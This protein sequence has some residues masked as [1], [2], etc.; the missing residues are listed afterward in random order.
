MTLI[1]R[2]TEPFY[3]N[4]HMRRHTGERPLMCS[5]CGK[6]FADPRS[7]KTHNLIHSGERPFKCPICR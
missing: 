4:V 6:S 7:F 3:L 2:F 1:N 5:T